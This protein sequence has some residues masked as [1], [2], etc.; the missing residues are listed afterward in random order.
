MQNRYVGDIGDF[1]KLGLLSA[2]CRA[3]Q[4][5]TLTLGI[6]WYFVPDSSTSYLARSTSNE[7]HYRPCDRPL[8]DK[9]QAIIEKRKK[10]ERCVRDIQEA[11]ILAGDTV[12]YGREVPSAEN[13]RTEWLD[14]A[15]RGTEHCDL[16]FLDPDNGIHPND[17]RP[18]RKHASIEEII[19]FAKR[20]RGEHSV[21]VYHHAG[22]K[23]K[24]KEQLCLQ[25]ERLRGALHR[26]TFGFAFHGGNVRFFLIAAANPHRAILVRRALDF[27]RGPWCRQGLFDAP[28]W[29]DGRLLEEADAQAV[30]HAG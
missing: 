6:V 7:R 26:N 24:A 21:I 17:G 15:L 11:G 4:G 20:Q 27:A 23:G 25:L 29:V 5:R 16:V 8:Y 28:A 3:L 22:R 13:P 19:K 30:T 1:G 2:L 12:F 9:L 18:D 14:K 10:E